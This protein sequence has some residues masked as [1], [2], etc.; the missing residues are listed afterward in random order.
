MIPLAFDGGWSDGDPGAGRLR[1]DSPRL[2]DIKHFHISARD[3]AACRIGPQ[4]STWGV[5]E[6]IVIERTGQEQNRVV[7]WVIGEVINRGTYYSVPVSLRSAVGSFAEHDSLTVSHQ[8]NLPAVPDP[9]QAALAPTLVVR[10]EPVQT[11]PQPNPELD[12]LR[13]ENA[14]L[15]AILN[16]LSKDQTQVLIP[17][18]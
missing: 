18:D 12:R 8:L 2:S 6:V 4:V 14:A 7:A 15:M 16:D 17:H 5:G 13:A 11:Q 3:A 9:Q 10:S 1:F